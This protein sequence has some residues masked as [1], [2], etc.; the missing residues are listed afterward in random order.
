M[1][2]QKRSPLHFR[3]ASIPYEAEMKL[4][5]NT[6]CET[7]ALEFIEAVR[8]NGNKANKEFLMPWFAAAIL[9]GYDQRSREEK[10]S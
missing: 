7:W 6:S 2:P 3:K 1:D 4:H 5:T 9:C 10:K 8:R